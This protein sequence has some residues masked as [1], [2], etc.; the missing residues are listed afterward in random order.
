M[1]RGCAGILFDTHHPPGPPLAA[2]HC[3]ANQMTKP[4]DLLGDFSWKTTPE[5]RIIEPHGNRI[6]RKKL[7]GRW[8][9]DKPP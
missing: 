7:N 2:Q 3:K 5:V 6:H 9:G 8:S 1:M 4:S